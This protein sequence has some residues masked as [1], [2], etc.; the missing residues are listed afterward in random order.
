M[1][2]LCVFVYIIP[3]FDAES[4]LD[5]D[6]DDEEHHSLHS[7]GEQVLSHHVPL[8]RRAEPVLTCSTTT[9]FTHLNTTLVQSAARTF[10]NVTL[11]A[12]HHGNLILC[13]VFTRVTE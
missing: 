13:R 7:H 6:G 12:E 9:T 8:Q 5:E 11:G 10:S 3:G 1:I 4:V 2:L